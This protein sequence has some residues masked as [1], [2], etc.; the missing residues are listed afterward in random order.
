MPCSTHML[1]R[2]HDGTF[3]K[4][5]PNHLKRYV[6]EFVGKHN[7]G[8]QERSTGCGIRSL[9]W[10][11]G[12]SFSVISSLA[13]AFRRGPGLGGSPRRNKARASFSG[14]APFRSRF[15]SSIALILRVRSISYPWRMPGGPIAPQKAQ[16]FPQR[17]CQNF[18]GKPTALR[19]SFA[20]CR[21]TIFAGTDTS[22]CPFLAQM[23]WLPLGCLSGS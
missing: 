1:T 19:M 13:T 17:C 7:L 18:L 16:H 22:F 9:G 14:V 8:I 21:D 12:T 23:V 2:A 5:S 10:S 4:I 6:Y 3:H 20:V 15:G 11:A